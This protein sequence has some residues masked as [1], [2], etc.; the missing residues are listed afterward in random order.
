MGRY[1]P[2]ATQEQKHEG[3]LQVRIDSVGTIIYTMLN[4]EN[5]VIAQIET[6][7]D[8]AANGGQGTLR[9]ANSASTR[10]PATRRIKATLHREDGARQIVVTTPEGD[11]LARMH[12]GH[13]EWREA[14][15]AALNELT[16]RQSARDAVELEQHPIADPH[17]VGKRLQA[18]I[19][20]SRAS[21]G[22]EIDCLDVTLEAARTW[23]DTQGISNEGGMMLGSRVYDLDI[24]DGNHIDA[25]LRVRR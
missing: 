18:A 20:E 8:V 7:A 17:A 25:R 10:P 22:T 9:V 2:E 16:R 5:D 6:D 4:D 24:L 1:E 15:L 13:E 3:T 21:S 11:S 12:L 23:L 14:E 19:K